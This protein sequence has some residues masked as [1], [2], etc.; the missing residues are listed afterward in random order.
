MK[1]CIV[2]AYHL[3][4]WGGRPNKDEYDRED[5]LKGH[6]PAYRKFRE[7]F[8]ES[9]WSYVLEYGNL[10]IRFRLDT[11]CVLLIECL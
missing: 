1:T 8:I 4:K 11:Y 5:P 2:N 3:A 10:I 6:T 7:A 9:L